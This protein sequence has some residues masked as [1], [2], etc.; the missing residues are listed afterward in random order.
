[1]FYDN[2]KFEE[3]YEKYHKVKQNFNIQK[4]FK[5][6]EKQL[7][8]KYHNIEQQF[9]GGKILK[10]NIQTSYIQTY[11]LNYF[12]GNDKAHWAENVRSFNKLIIKNLYPMIDLEMISDGIGYKYN[13]ICRPGS[14]PSLIKIKYIGASALQVTSKSLIIKTSVITY[15]EHL[16]ESYLIKNNETN[17]NILLKLKLKDNILSFEN[18]PESSS[19]F[20]LVIDPKL[21]FSTYSGSTADNFGFTATY[22]LM[23]NLYAGGITTGPYMQIPNGKYPTTTGAFSETYNGGMDDNVK[24]D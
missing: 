17:K 3:L 5:H 9:I 12:L 13:F 24:D 10:E 11:K 15:S 16:P 19:N 2:S 1:M 6:Q 22:D 14:N 23:G 7:K 4:L 18:L 20:T 21:I 8:I